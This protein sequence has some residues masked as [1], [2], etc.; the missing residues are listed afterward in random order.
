MSPPWMPFFL[1]I[2]STAASTCAAKAVPNSIAVA[3]DDFSVQLFSASQVA[4]LSSGCASAMTSPLS[5]S[6]LL[7]N[8]LA[9]YT[10]NTLTEAN[11]TTLCDADCTK[12]IASYRENV[13]RAC[14]NDISSS[15]PS[16]GSMAVPGTGLHDDIYN[17]QGGSV[18]PVHLADYFLLNHKINCL[19]DDSNPAQWCYLK[20]G[21]K[22]IFLTNSSCDACSLGAV[23]ARI[24]GFD[25]YTP[26]L[27]SAWSSQV[28]SVCKTT[29]APLSTPKYSVILADNNTIVS[30]YN[31]TPTSCSGIIVPVATN[32][33]CDDFAESHGIGTEQ[34]LAINQLQSGCVNFPGGKTSLCIQGSCKT[35][36]VVAN[37]T[38]RRI[39]HQFNLWPLQVSLWNPVLDVQCRD[40]ARMVGRI[41][42]ISN[43]SGYT[44][45]TLSL[46]P[47][48][49]VSTPVVSPPSR[50]L[51]AFSNLPT[52]TTTWTMPPLPTV[53]ATQFPLA[54]G[55]ISG[56]F[57]MWDN[58]Y[59]NMLCEAAA[60]VYGADVHSWNTSYCG[61]LYNPA[62]S[63]VT[64]L[65]DPA[66]NFVPPPE[67]STPGATTRCLVWYTTVDGDTCSSV[68]SDWGITMAQFYAWNPQIGPQCQSMWSEAAYCVSSP[69]NTI[70]TLT[71]APP[72]LKSSTSKVAATTTPTT[73]TSVTPPGPT[74]PG[75]V[76]NCKMYALARSGQTCGDF[77]AANG[78]TTANLYAW[79]TVLSGNCLHFAPGAAYCIRVSS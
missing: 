76:K 68:L 57:E 11:L 15:T 8:P 29:A 64:N 17:I 78:I 53:N 49:T 69:D 39:A 45:P 30:G 3:R 5:C 23:R 66:N 72:P 48:S 58:P 7:V 28:T 43:P 40:L 9:L 44:T 2:W 20:A 13:L 38:C 31:P 35:Y 70:S 32:A 16:D 77:A 62:N 55:S 71:S 61:L 79:N 22:N 51:Q 67:G 18:R 10:L 56:C 41:L 25:D 60:A 73:T 36:K 4:S 1:A 19:Q 6:D 24:E 52:V 37:D 46:P 14:A 21:E 54:N 47:V 65:I 74:Q 75:I 42:C 34:L 27:A 63:N 12:S 26:Q 59:S 50:S 33:N